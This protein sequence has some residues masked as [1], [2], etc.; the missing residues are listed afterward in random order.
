M[1]ERQEELETNT[2]IGDMRSV[3]KTTIN[4]EILEVARRV[5]SGN[6]PH[7]SGGEKVLSERYF[8]IAFSGCC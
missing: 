3:N 5:L 4:G 2:T 7:L 6:P 1:A 8:F